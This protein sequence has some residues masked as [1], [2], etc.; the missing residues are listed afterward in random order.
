MPLRRV[1]SKV[2]LRLADPEGR[3]DRSG[4]P[5]VH[6]FILDGDL[7]TQIDSVEDGIRLVWPLVCDEYSEVW[8]L[9]EGPEPTRGSPSPGEIPA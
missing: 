3:R 7:A 4:R 2:A 8:Q 9:P 1:G 5:I 6:E